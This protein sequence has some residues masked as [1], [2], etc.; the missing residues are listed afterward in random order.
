LDSSNPLKTPILK[1]H[2]AFALLTSLSAGQMAAQG[3]TTL[4]SFVFTNGTGPVA[5]LILSGTTLYG[6]TRIYGGGNG[7]GY[8]SVFK[9]GVDGANFSSLHIFSG[10]EDGGNLNSSLVLADGIL[11]GTATF[12]GGS[13]HGCVF[14]ISTNGI[15]LTNLYSFSAISTNFPS[16]NSDGAYPSGGLVLAGSTLYGTANGGGTAGWGNVFAI[17]TNGTAFT[18]LHNF[19]INDGQYPSATLVLSGSTLYGMTAGGGA[20]HYGNILSMNTNGTGITNLYSFPP[21]SGPLFTNTAGAFP[22]GGLVLSGSTLYGAA[23]EGGTAGS[24]TIFKINTDGSGFAVLHTFSAK[25]G[26]PL[27]NSDGA[28]PRAELT[29]SN[30]TLYGTA[31]DGGR[32]G[33]GTVFRLNTDGTGFATL[34]SFTATNGVPGTNIDGAHPVGGLILANNI[35]YGT[36][37]DGGTTG[38]GTVFSLRFPPVLGI[39]LS[40]TN[41]ILT[42][43]T[44]VT[45]FNL[46]TTTN[47]VPPI[48]WSGV[49]GQYAVTNPASSKQRFFR[50][51]HP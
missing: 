18:N 21:T 41:V 2:I 11:Y 40:G 49:S 38:Y 48:L 20:F 43:P 6:T 47:L 22:A 1:L 30:G 39:Q 23:P 42:W 35:L 26:T 16:T 33:N 8:G 32:A 29:V 7:G 3:F 31:R 37:R 12:G 24:G 44:N 9:L 51:N 46:E 28:Y 27:T 45:G 14:A 10:N 4:H 5:T 17:T 25:S 36:A 13:N 19:A 15:G 50:L 34:Y